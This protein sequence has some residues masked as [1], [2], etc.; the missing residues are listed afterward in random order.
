M[1]TV[2]RTVGI[3]LALVV[4]IVVA[5]KM[6]AGSVIKLAVE[7]EG[8]KQLGAKVDV[9]SASMTFFPVGVE[10]FGVQATDPT[11][12]MKNMV[13][14]KR[15]AA[16]VEIAPLFQ[17][18]VV[19]PEAFLDNLLFNTD[20]AHSGALPG[21][22]A[23]PRMPALSLTLPDPAT[24]IAQLDLETLRVVQAL[25]D[26]LASGKEQW[27]ANV[28]QLTNTAKIDSWKKRTD[29]IR[30]NASGGAA[31][32]VQAISEAQQILKEVQGEF[33]ALDSTEKQFRS[34]VAR[35]QQLALAASKAPAA[36]LQA[37]K[38][39]F[40][41]NAAGATALGE[42]LLGQEIRPWVERLAPF[43]E[44]K[45]PQ[46]PSE[47]PWV[48][49]VNQLNATASH[50]GGTLALTVRGISTE[51]VMSTPVAVLLNAENFGILSAL[52]GEGEFSAANIRAKFNGAL[53]SQAFA[54]KITVSQPLVAR[55]L[56]GALKAQPRV[57]IEA[58]LTGNWDQYALRIRSAIDQIAGQALNNALNQQRKEWE[59]KIQSAI[60]SATSGDLQTLRQEL[61]DMQN[62]QQHFTNQR[63]SLKELETQLMSIGKGGSRVNIKNLFR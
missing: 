56:Q 34:D 24:I 44:A 17:Q 30:A 12:P 20:R 53:A 3:L 23:A 2:S 63:T 49:F 21:V 40:P 58:E 35:W 52:S 26:E 32:T 39:R 4:I 6:Y 41:F 5:V 27:M 11:N 19:I 54:D 14:A 47:N 28:A 48:V 37:I 62:L 1:R 7:T 51:T 50:D 42:I 59:G 13:E 18:K 25:Q 29:D 45:E 9:A 43:F 38:T 15:I 8:S 46:A 57:P 10:L 31:K 60:T 33:Q 61:S 22:S 55:A 16:R 36:D